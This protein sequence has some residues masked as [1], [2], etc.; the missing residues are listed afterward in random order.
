[1]G[2]SR[3]MK[4]F[5]TI[6]FIIALIINSVAFCKEASSE[7]ASFE[8]V[9]DFNSFKL[10][11]LIFGKGLKIADLKLVSKI[12]SNILY[13]TW[14]VLRQEKDANRPFIAHIFKYNLAGKFPVIGV[15]L[16]YFCLRV[17]AF[18]LEMRKQKQ[19]LRSL[20][21]NDLNIHHKTINA[22]KVSYVL[23]QKPQ[24]GDYLY[25]VCN[26]D[27]DL[28]RDCRYQLKDLSSG[29]LNSMKYSADS[30]EMFDVYFPINKNIFLYGKKPKFSGEISRNNSDIREIGEWKK[31]KATGELE[32]M[33]DEDTNTYLI[34]PFFNFMT[35]EKAVKK[36]Q[37]KVLAKD[38]KQAHA[39][40]SMVYFGKLLHDMYKG[41]VYKLDSGFNP[42]EGG[43]NPNI[44]KFG[45][46]TDVFLSLHRNDKTMKLRKF[47]DD[48]Y[49]GFKK[50]FVEKAR[51]YVVGNYT[52]Q[53]K[54]KEMD[55]ELETSF[56]GF[57]SK[58]SNYDDESKKQFDGYDS[59][60]KHDFV[61]TEIGRKKIR[62]DTSY[63]I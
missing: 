5:N 7:G 14:E 8:H 15:D 44:I 57:I 56:A 61:K 38:I 31:Q 63:D 43:F 50:T 32:K 48:E 51:K 60:L 24:P 2:N 10:N 22:G 3:K 18:N 37:E 35:P 23:I 26:P 59:A 1:M 28:Q 17:N 42:I 39:K 58:L 13:E 36:E 19:K 53:G 46:Y 54:Q 62:S 34:V 12:Q 6:N 47:W 25:D 4:F 20:P 52:N 27:M 45:N 40:Q 11:Q 29:F 9:V 55:G 16:K 30:K 49:F 41:L 21:C 33:N